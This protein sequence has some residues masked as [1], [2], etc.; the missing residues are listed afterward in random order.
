M[1]EH[2]EQECVSHQKLV[3]ST[4]TLQSFSLFSRQFQTGLLGLS[5]YIM[6]DYSMLFNKKLWLEIK[7][8]GIFILEFGI[9]QIKS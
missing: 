9:V 3:S 1:R 4:L 7:H 2:R 8:R 5:E 6:L